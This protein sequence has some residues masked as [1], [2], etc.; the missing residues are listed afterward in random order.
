MTPE[1]IAAEVLAAADGAWQVPPFTGRDPAFGLAEAYEVAAL[2]RAARR[3]QGWR[4]VGRKLGFTNRAIWD[5]YGVHMPIVG[6]LW[7]RT[8][9]DAPGGRAEIAVAA[10]TEPLIEP[11]IAFG[12]ARP[13]RADMTDA[14]LVACMAW[15]AHGV[16]IVR[17]IYP[18]WVFR[19]PDTVAALA[20]HGA[21]RIGPKHPVTPETAAHWA[22]RLAGF[23]VSLARNGTVVERGD[24][25]LVL[26]GP[27][28]VMRH[29]VR[30]L[31]ASPDDT[32]L[33]P[34]EMVT[35]GTLTNTPAIA[36]GEVWTTALQG[37]PLEGINLTVT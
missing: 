33:E 11:E 32:P 27:L 15:V 5:R 36:P 6:D 31:A 3:R 16:E 1:A 18:G 19:A 22:A 10:F 8:V 25:S 28:E 29:L 4:R 7:D 14:E 9:A 12:I 30:H 13:P 2:I 20:L 23:R 21:Y 24:A 26:G 37:L 34:G 35:T 17:S